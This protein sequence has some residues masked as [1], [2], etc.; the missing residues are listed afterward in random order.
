MNIRYGFYHLKSKNIH[1]N[2][3]ELVSV[4][5]PTYNRD[6]VINRALKSVIKQTYKNIE[7]LIIDDGSKDDTCNV[8]KS[9][10]NAHTNHTISYI[11]CNKNN[12]AQYARNL[13]IAQAHGQ[14]ITFL[15]SD[16]EYLPNKIEVS[17][18]YAKSRNYKV[19]H[20]DCFIVDY[21]TGN[22]KP[23]GVK[24]LEGN[25]F[26]CLLKSSG[27][28]FPG[29]MVNKVCFES[30]FTFDESIVAHQEWD[31]SIMLSRNYKFGFIDKPLFIWHRGDQTSISNDTT[32]GN[33]G[34]WQII[35]KYKEDIL[36]YLGSR[37][38]S[39]HYFFLA[40][41]YQNAQEYHYVNRLVFNS[42]R[43]EPN[44]FL[45]IL[46]R[47]QQVQWIF[48]KIPLK[49]LDTVFITRKLK[50]IYFG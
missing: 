41:R 18:N 49:L 48:K 46:K 2:N 25:I 20:C 8:V 33:Y 34:Y 9:F 12:G 1:K 30:G 24:K 37:E 44:K 47:I 10:V 42:I 38:L 6:S 27:P 4:I 35:E 43:Y 5:I 28:V 15:D 31:I 50:E 14:W 39:Y 40:C 16:D 13:G 21:P 26:K 36:N 23:L 11:K 45:K 17:L 29:L 32:R 22:A 3:V 7:I 19:V